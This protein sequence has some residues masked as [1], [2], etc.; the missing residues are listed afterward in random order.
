MAAGSA[1]PSLHRVMGFL[2]PH[3]EEIQAAMKDTN[4]SEELPCFR[5]LKARVPP[6][7]Y[8][9]WA[10]LRV[11]AYLNEADMREFKIED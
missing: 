5:E 10:N 6:A 11:E 8:E 2:L 1:V 9:A 7:W 3:M 4:F